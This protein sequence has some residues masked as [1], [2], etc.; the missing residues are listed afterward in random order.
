M[1]HSDLELLYDVM[2]N[3][4]HCTFRYDKSRRRWVAEKKQ[5]FAFV[6]RRYGFKFTQIAEFLSC[7]HATVISNYRTMR[8]LMDIYPSF[9]KQYYEILDEYESIETVGILAQA[10]R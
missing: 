10:G 9:R 2:V 1:K 6:A 3:Y 5:M 8:D 4:Y 7:T